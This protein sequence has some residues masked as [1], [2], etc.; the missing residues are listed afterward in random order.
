[1]FHH[2]NALTLVEILILFKLLMN[3][4]SN[5]KKY[6]QLN[7][8][9]I[10]IFYWFIMIFSVNE[11]KR[12]ILKMGTWPWIFLPYIQPIQREN[13]L[14]PLRIGLIYFIQ[15]IYLLRKLFSSL[16]C[17]RHQDV[18]P[19]INPPS[20]AWSCYTYSLQFWINHTI[21]FSNTWCALLNSTRSP[22][23]SVF[24]WLTSPFHV[25]KHINT[26]NLVHNFVHFSPLILISNKVKRVFQGTSHNM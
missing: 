4:F 13:I 17:P 16:L 21:P 7:C 5:T 2:L 15:K 14:S 10:S 19:T 12:V 11:F 23:F 6:W 22:S 9:W 18:N 8:T 24:P 1:M 25:I 26:L 20:P 3:T